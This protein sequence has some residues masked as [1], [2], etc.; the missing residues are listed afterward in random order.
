MTDL[1]NGIDY[2]PKSQILELGTGEAWV[3]SWFIENSKL[4]AIGEPKYFNDGL[5]L[6]NEIIENLEPLEVKPP[7]YHPLSMLEQSTPDNLT[8]WLLTK[9]QPKEVADAVAKYRL[10]GIDK[11]WNASTVFWQIDLEGK[12]RSG[13]VI[14]YAAENGKRIKNP[15]PRI[16]WIHSILK[17]KDFNL[18]QVPYGFHLIKGRPEAEVAVVESE[19]TAIYMS[20]K[21]PNKIWI[22]VGSTSGL[23][24][25]LLDSIKDRKI[26]AYPDKGCFIEW[27]TKADVMNANGYNNTVN[28]ALEAE[29]HLPDGSDLID[30]YELIK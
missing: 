29:D 20:I 4:E 30:Y 3:S 17:A 2:V 16:T 8:K 14:N 7:S 25:G 27:K 24:P 1:Y 13:K 9:F 21:A 15:Y 6:L 19:K 22:S 23:K 18:V 11:P 10:T 5:E 26:A 12:I 28:E